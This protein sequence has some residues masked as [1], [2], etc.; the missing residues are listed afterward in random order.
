MAPFPSKDGVLSG[1][2]ERHHDEGRWHSTSMSSTV[3]NVRISGWPITSKHIW[4]VWV[5]AVLG[6]LELMCM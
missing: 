2:P 1:I 3:G 6:G 5:L 4:P